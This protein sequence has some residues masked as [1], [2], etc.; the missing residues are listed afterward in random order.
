MN[1][2][3]AAVASRIQE[4]N[5][6]LTSELANLEE[7]LSRLQRAESD[8]ENE[9]SMTTEVR[10]R[11]LSAVR[12]RHG[13]ELDRHRA[14][15]DAN[16]LDGEMIELRKDINRLRSRARDLELTFANVD[17][18]VYA[19][20][21]VSTSLYKI[22][23]ERKLESAKRRRRLRAERLNCLKERTARHVR[24]MDEMRLERD[25]IT[26]GF[27]ELDRREEEDDEETMALGMQIKSVLAKVRWTMTANFYPPPPSPDGS[28]AHADAP[29]ISLVCT[30][31]V[32]E[33]SVERCEGAAANGVVQS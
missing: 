26:M 15:E 18:K 10:I 17:A 6:A 1:H 2:S 23:L 25:R 33:I 5:N 16:R 19:E 3:L 28:L 4:R 22:M 30:E 11:L 20:H 14:S 27:M 24:D 9:I 13:T 32:R 7:L 29:F 8:L 12:S 21:D 31:S